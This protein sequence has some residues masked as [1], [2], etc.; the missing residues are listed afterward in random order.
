MRPFRISL[1]GSGV[2][3]NSSSCDILG[4]N[5]K[6]TAELSSSTQTA[7]Q[8]FNFY[9]P[10][11]NFSVS[12]HVNSSQID[13][14]STDEI[15]SAVDALIQKEK[16]PIPLDDAISHV[17]NVQKEKAFI[18]LTWKITG[19]TTPIVIL[20]LI[21]VI[22]YCKYHRIK[23]PPPADQ[24]LPEQPPVGQFINTD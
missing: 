19:S 2:I 6:F 18:S 22:W 20:A 13:F 23:R 3:F 10:E 7:L 17:I 4:Q 5:F 1:E 8:S 21:I 12:D 24:A 16:E 15:I 11:L 9:M 14:N